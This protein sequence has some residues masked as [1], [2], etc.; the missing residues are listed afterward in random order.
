MRNGFIWLGAPPTR[1]LW[2]EFPLDENTFDVDGEY[3]LGSAL[4]IKPV[5]DEGAITASVYFPHGLWYDV[6]DL[7]VFTGPSTQTISAPKEKVAY[8]D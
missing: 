7:A 8:V 1:P 3:M 5:V 4:L 6:K 2:V